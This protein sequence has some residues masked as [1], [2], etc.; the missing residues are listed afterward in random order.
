MVQSST[1][2]PV[3]HPFSLTLCIIAILKSMITEYVYKVCSFTVHSG[4]F[5]SKFE[6]HSRLVIEPK[7]FLKH[8]VEA[9]CLFVIHVYFINLIT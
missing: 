5:D 6:F 7:H 8:M 3:L 4:N 9:G 1:D 2:H